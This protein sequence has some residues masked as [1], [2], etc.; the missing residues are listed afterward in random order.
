[1]AFQADAFQADAFQLILPAAEGA[2]AATFAIDV[3]AG[4]TVTYAWKT[5]VRKAWSGIET[6]AAIL[7]K[8]RQSYTF[9]TL[10][11]DA[12]HRRILTT[13]AEET[14]AAPLFQLA[15]PYEDLTVA[16]S[17]AGAVTVHDLSLCD[18]AIAGQRVV[19]VAPDGTTGEAV[20]QNASGNSISVDE[21]LT[22]VAIDGARIMPTVGVLLEP[23]Q[24][25]SRWRVGAGRWQ[26]AAR[27]QRNGFALGSVPGTGSSVTTY[28]SLPVWDWGNAA[29]QPS[30][31][32]YAG[33]AVVDLGARLSSLQAYDVADWGRAIRVSSSKRAD[34]QWLKA[35][36]HEIRGSWG[37]FLLPTGRPDLVP[38]GDA[39]SGT[40][41]ISTAS[42]TVDYVNAWFPSLAHRRIKLV[43]T[44]GAVAYREVQSCSDGGA[45][46]DLALD[47][48]FTGTLARVE[49]LET[50]RLASDEVQVQWRGVGFEASLA[51]RVVQG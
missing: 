22:A 45:T 11:S 33:G 1:M 34:W 3:E 18:W 43:K 28:D 47:S 9:S 20:V 21:D 5:T 24:G 10:L 48:S 31:P 40:L 27:A 49:F 19:V 37:T 23:E 41:T 32:L 8:P 2:G 51:A 4:A 15:L 39:S 42:S 29:E 14:A 44:D 6:R 7:G 50:C 16:S 38:V 26:V 46:Q 13:L 17:T 25:L 30:Q 36:L 35:M 12:Q